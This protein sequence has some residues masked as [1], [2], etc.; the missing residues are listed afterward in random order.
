[1]SIMFDSMEKSPLIPV[2]FFAGTAVAAK[3]LY[4]IE[5]LSLASVGCFSA[6]SVITALVC[7]ILLEICMR[8]SYTKLPLLL[9][10]AICLTLS[11]TLTLSILSS[12]GVPLMLTSALK[13]VGSGMFSACIAFMGSKLCS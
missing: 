4:K 5:H 7:D 12:A 6:V 3:A 1:M 13:I 9:R 8:D 10:T 11:T 2:A